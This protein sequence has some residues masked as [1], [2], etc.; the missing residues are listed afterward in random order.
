MNYYIYSCY[1]RFIC[2]QHLLT[3]SKWQ[4][5]VLSIIE[6]ELMVKFKWL[7]ILIMSD[8]FWRF[9]WHF[10]RTG[11]GNYNLT[12][13]TLHCQR[14]GRPVQ[15]RSKNDICKEHKKNPTLELIRRGTPHQVWAPGIP[16]VRDMGCETLPEI[17]T[18]VERIRLVASYTATY[19]ILTCWRVLLGDQLMYHRGIR[20]WRDN[21]WSGIIL[22]LLRVCEHLSPDSYQMCVNYANTMN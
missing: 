7:W 9:I 5:L 13:I 19:N 3:F 17:L 20:W 4:S 14:S 6:V 1:N 15:H 18:Y 10:V 2:I 22:V 11:F 21:S 16:W 8:Q 12:A